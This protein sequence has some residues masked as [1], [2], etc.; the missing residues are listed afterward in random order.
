MSRA[1]LAGP[2]ARVRELAGINTAAGTADY[3]DDA[4]AAVL[5]RN[6]LDFADDRLTALRE[7]DAGGTVRYYVHQ[8]RHRNLEAT[9]GGTA[10]LYVR[11]AAGARAGT[12]NYSVD[13]QAGRI[14]FVADTGGS[15]F[16]LTGR[17]YDVYAAAAEVWRMRAA[18]VAERFDFTADG[19][20]FK[21][22]QLIAQYQQMADQCAALATFGAGA[23]GLRS[24]T[25]VRDD[26]A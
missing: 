1:T 13:T 17:S 19:A 8:S 11:D 9:D 6:R 23:A 26:L 2:I 24:S 14:T 7:V 3:T 22:S 12:A 18:G 4:V 20:S 10:V 15:A 21:A 25:L 16:Y 5:D